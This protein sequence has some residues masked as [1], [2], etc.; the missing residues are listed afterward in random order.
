LYKTCSQ[1][2]NIPKS[3]IDFDSNFLRRASFYTSK[4]FAQKEQE[5]YE[6]AKEIAL[7]VTVLTTKGVETGWLEKATLL[8]L[9]TVV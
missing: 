2:Q 8:W 3:E 4:R 9:V 6:V 7:F 1:Q 5:S